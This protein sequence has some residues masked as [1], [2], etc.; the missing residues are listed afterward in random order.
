MQKVDSIGEMI[1]RNR[2]ARGI[3][4]DS[5]AILTGY[6][7]PTLRKLERGCDGTTIKTLTDVAQEVGIAI[8][9][10]DAG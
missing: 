9:V 8:E 2:K 4:L 7:V 10:R 1:R 6:S 3:T 5:L